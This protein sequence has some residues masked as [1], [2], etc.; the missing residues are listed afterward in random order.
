MDRL[1]PALIALGVGA[2]LAVVLLVPFVAVSYRRRGGLTAGRSLAWLALLVWILGVQAYTLLPIPQGDYR[3]VGVV[4]NP[5]QAIADVT[6]PANMAN[7]ILRN[8]AVQQLALNVLLFAPWGVL[9]RLLWSRG[10]VVATATGFGISLLV[11]LT[12]VTGVWGAFP[13]AYRLFDTSDLLTNTAGAL[14]G[15]LLALPFA[16]R[17]ASAPLDPS[18]MTLGRRLIGMLCDVLVV[19]GITVAVGITTNV[20]QLYLFGVDRTQLDASVAD[21][22]GAIAAI[23]LTGGYVL[24]TGSTLGERAVRLRGVDGQRPVVVWRLVRFIT[25]IGGYQL[26]L[27]LDQQTGVLVFT[28]VTVI[29]AWRS[30]QHR[31]LAHLASGMRL[32]TT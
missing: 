30:E 15:S 24:A 22:A 31:G 16:R 29:L 9:V 1:I 20:V 28:I 25:G 12:Q 4:W 2:V 23:L 7:G 18:R 6:D 14:L 8:P 26:L 5:L 21:A 19:L 17:R 11:E 3:C 10:F 13:C 27:L 32:E